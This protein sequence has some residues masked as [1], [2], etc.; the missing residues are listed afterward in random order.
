V[1]FLRHLTTDMTQADSEPDNLSNC[2]TQRNLTDEGRQTARRLGQAFRTLGIPVGDVL[3]SEYCRTLET[4]RLAFG[5]AETVPEL[6]L[7]YPMETTP[8]AINHAAEV[9]RTLLSTI[10]RAGT[11]TVVVSHGANLLRL[12]GLNLDQEGEVAI[13]QPTGDGQMI[14]VANILPMEWIRVAQ[15]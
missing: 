12:T 7:L 1:I 3:S 5:R 15:Q 9:L 10:P 11:N 4:A 14:L 2:A 8:D 13:Y 6:T